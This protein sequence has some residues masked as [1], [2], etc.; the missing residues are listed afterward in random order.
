MGAGQPRSSCL[1]AFLSGMFESPPPNLPRLRRRGQPW[2]EEPG[3]G[4]ARC[5]EMGAGQPRLVCWLALFSNPLLTSPRLRGGILVTSDPL[6]KVPPRRG[7][8]LDG[9][10]V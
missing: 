4:V 7:M 8:L 1:F 2:G 9:L 6:P 5:V 10:G 3:E